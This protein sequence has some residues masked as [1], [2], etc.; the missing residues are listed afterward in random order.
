M[1]AKLSILALGAM[2]LVSS[3]SNDQTVDINDG[4]AIKFGVTVGKSS[5]ATENGKDQL[6]GGFMVWANDGTNNIIDGKK[7]SSTDGNNWTMEGGV[8]YWPQSNLS[9]FAL[10]PTTISATIN[11]TTKSFDYTVTDGATDVLYASNI[12]MVRPKTATPVALNFYHALSQIVFKVKNTN[13]EDITVVV[14]GIEIKN[15][16]SKGTFAWGGNT[17]APTDNAT[18]HGGWTPDNNSENL[19]TY[20]AWTGGSVTLNTTAVNDFSVE[21][22]P[23][24]KAN[25][26]L[27]PQELN[28]WYKAGS[29]PA[30]DANGARVL[31]DCVITDKGGV[32]LWPK[33]GPDANTK[34]AISLPGTWSPGYK[35]TYT[36]VFG[37]GAGYDDSTPTDPTAV[38]VPISFSVSVDGFTDA[39]PAEQ[40]ING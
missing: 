32:Q 27:M 40:D 31:V 18:N 36:I 8:K 1:K 7:V 14:K 13:P 15:V 6:K 35:Y 23:N 12:N 38:L 21:D 20:S 34:V 28:P 30:W 19:K 29:T 4:N 5:R 3:C 17:T 2:A 24:P 22:D 26:F 37:Q 16:Y 9:F 33:A 25:L 11:S 10:Y 39:T